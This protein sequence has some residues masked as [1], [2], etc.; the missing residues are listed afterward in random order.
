MTLYIGVD[1][2]A[3]QAMDHM[4]LL[5]VIKSVSPGH[6]LTLQVII[7]DMMRRILPGRHLV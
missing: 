7:L 5:V 2:R 6:L 3:L 1:L 4:V